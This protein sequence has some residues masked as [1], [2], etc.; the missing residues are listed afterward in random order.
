MTPTIDK[1][2][3]STGICD[4]RLVSARAR[5]RDRCAAALEEAERLE[6]L[7]VLEQG[8]NDFPVRRLLVDAFLGVAR[9]QHGEPIG[10]GE[11]KLVVRDT[12]DHAVHR[13]GR[14]DA[15]AQRHAGD[16][17]HRRM[18]TPKPECVADVGESDHAASQS[19]P[20]LTLYGWG[21]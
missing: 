8:A 20:L 9:P 7:A 13:G 6:R 5:Q 2:F 12:V 16:G 17:N 11:T 3:T 1:A 14:A 15:K 19:G 18:P 10:V 4:T 21:H